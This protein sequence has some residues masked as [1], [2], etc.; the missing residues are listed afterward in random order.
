VVA[1]A[2]RRVLG[3]APTTEESVLTG[4]F[5]HRQ[6]KNAGSRGAAITELGRSLFNLNEFLYVD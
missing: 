1:A 6:S 4:D 5:L 2:F 3:R